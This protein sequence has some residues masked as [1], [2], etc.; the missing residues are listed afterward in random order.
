MC[1]LWLSHL[2]MESFLFVND[3]LL[4]MLVSARSSSTSVERLGTMKGTIRR[5]VLPRLLTLS[6]FGLVMIVV[7]KV[8]LG[9]DAQRRLS[10]KKLEKFVDELMLLRMLNLK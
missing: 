2:L 3:V 1:E 5:R 9:T 7:S 6:L 4:A 10:K 8:I